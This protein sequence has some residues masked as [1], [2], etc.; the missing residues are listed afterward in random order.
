MLRTTKSNALASA[1]LTAL[2]A[3]L[4]LGWSSA[5]QA[6]YQIQQNGHALDASNRV[7]SGGYNGNGTP[8][9]SINI[10]N[11]IVPYFEAKLL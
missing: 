11:N 1:I 3:V 7:G 8:Y 10:N 5:S 6:Q 9:G 4:L 2:P